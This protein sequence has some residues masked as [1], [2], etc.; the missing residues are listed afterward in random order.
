MK[1]YAS[2]LA[3][4]RT[5]YDANADARDKSPVQ[6]WKPVLWEAFRLRLQQEDATRL[7]EIGSGTG[8]AAKY[9]QDA[10]LAVVCTDLS[11]QMVRLCRQKGLEAYTMAF[12]QLDFA[13]GRFDA[14]FAQNC[15]LHV[16]KAEFSRALNSVARV[17]KPGGLLFI[18]SHGGNSFE[19]VWPED[20][21][22]PK[23]F[24]SLYN[25]GEM[26]RILGR[27]FEIVNFEVFPRQGKRFSEF[28]AATLRNFRRSQER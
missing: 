6:A 1:E 17:V 22:E 19:G 11:P 16:P 12:T 24:Y 4:L 23:R 2:V 25:A 21:Y 7:L 10:G 27:H 18:G 15:L 8:Q 13:A 9:F 26:Q 14:L 20:P 5:A 28:H 3:R